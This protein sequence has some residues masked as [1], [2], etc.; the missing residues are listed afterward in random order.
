MERTKLH[1]QL[2]VFFCLPEHTKAQCPEI[3]T[4]KEIAAFQHV[5]ASPEKA[6]WVS[7]FPEWT[8]AGTSAAFMLIT[9]QADVLSYSK[10]FLRKQLWI[11]LDLISAQRN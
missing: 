7:G 8:E 2:T 11:A 3:K 9:T 4:Q 5:L 6:Y 1:Q 10:W